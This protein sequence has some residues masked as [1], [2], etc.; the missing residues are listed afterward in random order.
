MDFSLKKLIQLYL[1]CKMN[2]Y[3]ERREITVNN[4]SVTIHFSSSLKL[5][6]TFTIFWLNIY[7]KNMPFTKVYSRKKSQQGPFAKV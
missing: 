4:G 1:A 3:W 2:T 5:R 7:V 6:D